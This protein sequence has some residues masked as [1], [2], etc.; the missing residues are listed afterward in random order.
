MFLTLSLD[1]KLKILD[2]AVGKDVSI[3]FEKT[4]CTA[5][6]TKYILKL[7]DM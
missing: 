1:K 4:I 6:S 5:H 2:K 7:V 3:L